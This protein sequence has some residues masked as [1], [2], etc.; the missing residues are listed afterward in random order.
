MFYS[1]LEFVEFS[2]KFQTVSEL[3]RKFENIP[4]YSGNL[5]NNSNHSS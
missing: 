4:H 2:I 5:K 1:N 3:S